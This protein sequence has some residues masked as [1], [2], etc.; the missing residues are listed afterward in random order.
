MD[1]PA[2]G[3]REG[4]A[5][6]AD[7]RMSL[8]DP[9][10]VTVAVWSHTKRRSLNCPYDD[11]GSGLLPMH[12]VYPRRC[13]VCCPYEVDSPCLN[14]ALLLKASHSVGG[15]NAETFKARPTE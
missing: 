5:V 6:F 12:L 3:D 8:G 14:H 1:E 9:R 15:E 2:P 11:D 13:P 7:W 10:R 4:W